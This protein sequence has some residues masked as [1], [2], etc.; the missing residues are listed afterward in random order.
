MT[1]QLT[2]TKWK[3]ACIEE[4][5]IEYKKYSGIIWDFHEV[6]LGHAEAVLCSNMMDG[7]ISLK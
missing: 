5:L 3:P 7:M 6:S 4:D 2:P 1:A